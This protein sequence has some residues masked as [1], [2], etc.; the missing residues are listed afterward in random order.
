M[1]LSMRWKQPR[2]GLTMVASM[3]TTTTN[4]GEDE[5][6]NEGVRNAKREVER[7]E[8][9]ILELRQDKRDL[10]DALPEAQEAGRFFYPG[11]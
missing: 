6:S 7:L 1:M 9:L 2:T 3:V 11:D 5:D 10:L 8:A 4:D